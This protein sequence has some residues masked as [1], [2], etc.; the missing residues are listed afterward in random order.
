MASYKLDECTSWEGV[1]FGL[2]NWN[3]YAT[4]SGGNNLAL[5]G[6]LALATD[7]FFGADIMQVHYSAQLH[8]AELNSWHRY[9]DTKLSFMAGARYLNLN[10]R[11]NIH[12]VDSDA[13]ESDYNVNTRNQLMG[14][15]I[16]A[17]LLR[18]LDICT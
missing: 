16:G 5:P 14:G 6:D 4:A 15:Q 10:E 8:N 12:S 1:Y 17:R 2:Q 9:C 11:F 7:D 3:A 18:R 13:E